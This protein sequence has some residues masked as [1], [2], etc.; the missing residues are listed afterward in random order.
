MPASLSTFALLLFCLASVTLPASGLRAA[1]ALEDE[2][3]YAPEDLPWQDALNVDYSAASKKLE[4]LHEADPSDMRVAVAHAAALLSRDPVTQRNVLKARS[5]LLQIVA[6]LPQSETQYRPLAL[7]LIG[8]IDHDHLEPAQLDRARDF[9]DQLRNEYPGHELADQ[10]TVQL[11]MLVALQAPDAKLEEAA[12]KIEA[13]LPAV[14]A[15]HAKRELYSI[16]GNLHWHIHN[17]AAAALP[18]FI[19]GR[20]L[21]YEAFSR[22]S[23]MDIMIAGLAREIGLGELAAKHYRRFAEAEPRDTRAYT[24]MKLAREFEEASQ[25]K[26]SRAAKD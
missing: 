23:D 22:N 4:K 14:T 15:D 20:E 13:F 1:D 8:R 9:Y 2:T 6:T 11:A 12:A 3:E 17:D 18:L 16:A 5:L 10:A 24:A 7:Y 19:A 25:A 26:A 21:G